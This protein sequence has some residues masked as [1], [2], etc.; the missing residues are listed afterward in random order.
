VFVALAVDPPPAQP[1]A[2]R[3]VAIEKERPMARKTPICGLVTRCY[4]S[5]PLVLWLLETVGGGVKVD[6]VSSVDSSEGAQ[7]DSLN[8]LICLRTRWW[9]W[10]TTQLAQADQ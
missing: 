3:T 6:R 5:V 1:N 7:R 9:I 4:T 10:W 8:D 2:K